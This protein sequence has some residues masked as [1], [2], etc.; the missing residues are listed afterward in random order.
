ML[1]DYLSSEFTINE[2]S[3]DP[4]RLTYLIQRLQQANVSFSKDGMTPKQAYKQAKQLYLWLQIT[5]SRPIP[6]ELIY[7]TRQGL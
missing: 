5:F 2:I 1:E 6:R 4:Y 7:N 3:G